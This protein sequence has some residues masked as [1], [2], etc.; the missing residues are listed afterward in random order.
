MALQKQTVSLNLGNSVDQKDDELVGDANTFET[1]QDF[2]WDKE[3]RLAK[4]FGATAFG[5]TVSTDFPDPLTIGTSSIRSGVFA[6]KNQ[7]LLQN[8]GALYSWNE[9]NDSWVFKGHH[10]PLRASTLVEHA[11]DQ[12][13]SQPSITKFG[14][15]LIYSY[16][17]Y[18]GS[19]ETSSVR[20]RIYDTETDNQIVAD[21]VVEELSDTELIGSVFCIAFASRVYLVWNNINN[22]KITELN[23]PAGTFGAI[24]NLKTDC[25]NSFVNNMQWVVCNQAGVGERAF[26]LYSNLVTGSD[27]IQIFSIT[28]AGV[29]DATMGTFQVGLGSQPVALYYS[30]LF[31]RL[32]TAYSNAQ[33]SVTISA[34]D[35]LDVEI[36]T[37]TTSG[38]TSVFSENAKV[39]P[40]NANFPELPKILN[41]SFIDDSVSGNQVL[42]FFSETQSVYYGNSNQS[43]QQDTLM[44]KTYSSTASTSSF[45]TYSKNFSLFGQPFYRSDRDTIYLPCQHTSNSQGTLF[46]MDFYKGKYEGSVPYAFAQAK[47]AYR[48]HVSAASNFISPACQFSSSVVLFGSEIATRINDDVSDNPLLRNPGV[49][50]QTGIGKTTYNFQPTFAASKAFLAGSTH[51][52]GGYLGLYDGNEFCEHNF[53]LQPTEVEARAPTSTSRLAVAVVAEGGIG[54]EI[55]TVTFQGAANMVGFESPGSYFR[56]YTG[57]GGANSVTVGYKI[58]GVGTAPPPDGSGDSVLVELDGYEPSFE[59][60]LKT[61]QA[62]TIVGVNAGL[63]R[64]GTNNVLTITNVGTGNVTN[65]SAVNFTNAGTGPGAGTRSYCVV[66]SWIDNNGFQHRSAPSDQ[67]SVAVGDGTYP[68]AV[69]AYCPNLT[70]R[71]I[72]SVRA[73]IYSTINNGTTF[74]RVGLVEDMPSW[75]VGS[76]N[77]AFQVISTDTEISNNE[78]LYTQGGTLPNN[79]VEACKSVSVFKNRLVVSGTNANYVYYSKTAQNNLPVEIAEELFLAT[80]NDGQDVLGHH[81]LDDKLVVFKDQ[82]IVAYAGDGANDLGV[83]SSFSQPISVASD[84]G[85]ISQSSV[86]LVPDGLW[87][88]SKMGLQLITRGLELVYLGLPVKDF[89]SFLV[90]S[91]IVLKDDKNV[92]EIRFVLQDSTNTLVYNYLQ[93]KWGVFSQ[94]G[95]D[96]ACLWQG[97]FARVSSLGVV[98]VE[99]QNQWVDTGSSVPSYAPTFKTAWLKLKN[100][101]DYQRIW[102]MML[103]GVLK[104][105]HTLTVKAYY[106][107]DS[108]NFDTYTFLS[109]NIAGAQPDDTVYQPEFHLKRQKCQAIQFEVTVTSTGSNTEQALTLTDMSF[110]VGVKAGLNKTK[111]AKKL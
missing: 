69:T 108:T 46:L 17:S 2:I 38:F 86:A 14:N 31:S 51:L 63:D 8:K 44:W 74:F 81:Q 49:V 76:G 70:N 36:L 1:L 50:Y 30:S 6:H 60:M 94:Y 45:S 78:I 56:F 103:L 61:V 82:S 28:N 107:Y 24:S 12:K 105:A 95:G 88:Q 87:F 58:N 84:V 101:Q 100:V 102:R 20:Y 32:Y 83:N 37:F 15:Y 67:V 57:A 4:R 21:Q 98:H 29:I 68:V 104:T 9:Q 55:S 75:R 39:L 79:S 10:Y 77:V 34:T 7:L 26:C 18:D 42:F 89:N 109:S 110:S 71:E 92:R 3:K 66:W 5:T 40:G 62:L 91:S 43:E 33:P 25:E 85:G 13:I 59:V 106:D 72:S 96:N 93:R 16:V 99:Q 53:F 65:I 48:V 23:L 27:R 52:S 64:N 111:K 47:T 35:G 80:D 90:S 41:G 11:S 73:E 22:I 54:S 19:T 97:S